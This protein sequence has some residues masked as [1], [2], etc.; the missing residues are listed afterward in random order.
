MRFAA[1]TNSRTIFCCCS[2]SD[3]RRAYRTV[4]CWSDLYLTQKAS[5]NAL[6]NTKSTVRIWRW[7]TNQAIC[8]ASCDHANHHLD[9][10][11]LPFETRCSI[12]FL[13]IIFYSVSMLFRQFIWIVMTTI[14]KANNAIVLFLDKN[15]ACI[16]LIVV[17][18]LISYVHQR[19]VTS[20]SHM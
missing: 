3:H 17:I 1:S 12:Q 9:W 10:A 15:N 18:H 6:Y 7:C 8:T 2:C 14:C 16:K 13:N 5:R 19:H 20:V 4:F 11:W